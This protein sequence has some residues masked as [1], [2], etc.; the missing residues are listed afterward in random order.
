MRDL[1][2]RATLVFGVLESSR[3]I[4]CNTKLN[5]YNDRFGNIL[6]SILEDLELKLDVVWDRKT[7]KYECWIGYAA[8]HYQLQ[9]TRPSLLIKMFHKQA[10]GRELGHP[11]EGDGVPPLGP[12]TG[13]G[14]FHRAQ[15]GRWGAAQSVGPHSLD[16]SQ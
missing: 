13:E 14:I 15:A 3:P 5:S 12:Q 16:D 8:Q 10:M 1:S 4:T 7:I 2:P 11:F 9:Q 6:L